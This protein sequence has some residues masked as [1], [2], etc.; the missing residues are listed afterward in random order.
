MRKKLADGKWIQ[1]VNRVLSIILHLSGKRDEPAIF[2]I[3]PDKGLALPPVV[4]T[5]AAHCNIPLT[6]VDGV[7]RS[8]YNAHM[9]AKNLIA[10]IRVSTQKQ[11]QS[12]L[13]LEGQLAAID[14]YAK[15][16][17]GAV[18]QTY[19]EV[20]SG[21]RADRPEL[22]KA[23]T[24]AK[25][26]KA[27]LVIAKLDRLARNV[28]FIATVMDSGADF[29]ACDQPYANRLT[30]HILA[31]MAEHEAEQISH[32]TKAALASAKARGIPL[33][34]ARPNHW[35]GRE[36][37]R[38]AGLMKAV[39]VAKIKRDELAQPIYYHVLPLIRQWRGEGLSLQAIA[40]RLNQNGH[41]TVQGRDWNKVQ[42]SRLLK[43]AA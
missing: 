30:L 4:A 5:A 20:E 29:V 2:S 37:Q 40:H 26:I 28:A 17:N 16:N 13:G 15:A 12:G 1:E 10:Y 14:S 32:R 9:D 34:S 23:V 25:R 18:V 27:R 42:V 41:T 3:Y 33:G 6:D 8:G 36:T 38:K 39:Q 31:A 21:R 11:G 24:H 35:K 7:L 19:R 22:A 43:S